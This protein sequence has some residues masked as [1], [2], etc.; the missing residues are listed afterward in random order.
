MKRFLPLLLLSLLAVLLLWGC[1]KDVPGQETTVPEKSTEVLTVPEDAAVIPQHSGSGIIEDETTLDLRAADKTAA[2]AALC[3]LAFAPEDYLGKTVLLTGTYS[4]F[5][6][7]NIDY[8]Y[9]AVTVADATMCCAQV[10][11]FDPAGDVDPSV[12][13][14]NGEEITVSGVL[15]RYTMGDGTTSY[16]LTETRLAEAKE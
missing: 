1:R 12:F 11:Y 16:K 7:E 6:D 13:P 2:Y 9:R 3:A 5:Y 10:L 8:T 4:S 14:E 15:G